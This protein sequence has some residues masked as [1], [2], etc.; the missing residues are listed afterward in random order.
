TELVESLGR[1]ERAADF[2]DE[3]LTYW[4]HAATATGTAVISLIEPAP[5]SR[6]VRVW[7]GSGP[8]VVGESENAI[9]AWITNRLGSRPEGFSTDEAVLLWLG[10]AIPPQSYP[11]SANDLRARAR[12][13]QGEGARLLDDLAG[14][15]P[16]KL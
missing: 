8:W 6:L 14:A 16:R 10:E 3:F 11:N 9:D 13:A 7:R 5:P 1:G 2:L 12:V 15:A 4:R